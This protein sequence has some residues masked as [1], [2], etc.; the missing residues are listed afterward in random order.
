LGLAL[1]DALTSNIRKLERRY[2]DGFSCA[3]SVQRATPEVHESEQETPTEAVLKEHL[4]LH[5]WQ[6]GAEALVLCYEQTPFTQEEVSYLGEQLGALTRFLARCHIHPLDDTSVPASRGGSKRS[7]LDR[8]LGRFPGEMEEEEEDTV[9]VDETP[10]LDE[11]DGLFSHTARREVP[12]VSRLTIEQIVRHIIPNSY[13]LYI[14]RS[15]TRASERYPAVRMSFFKRHLKLI[16]ASQKGKSSMAA[17][18]LDIITR[19]H[20]PEHVLL[21][22]LDLEDQTSKLFAHLPH[23]AEVLV[24]DEPV[25][26]HARSREQV[27]EQ[28]G[29]VLS[30]MEYRYRLSK[31][32]LATEPILL[33]YVE[34]FL[35][36]KDYFK[37][38]IDSVRSG[39]KDQAKADY[40]QL[41][42]AISELARRG[43][44][45]RVQLLL[46][47]QVDY[48]D[49]D[50]QEALINITAGMSF[51]VRVTAAQAAGFY[52]VDLL[53]RNALDNTL[54]QAVVETPDCTDLV[55]APEYD[56]EQ[57]LLAFE[58]AELEQERRQHRHSAMA[59][60]L[61]L[62]ARPQT[63]R[64][65]VPSADQSSRRVMV[66]PPTPLA[67]EPDDKLPPVSIKVLAVP[68]ERK[69]QPALKDAIVCWNE[70]IEAGENPSRNN[71][72]QALLAKGFECKEYWARKFYEDIKEML[73]NQQQQNES[74]GE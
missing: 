46:C 38:R 29:Y 21:A 2:P 26:L 57:R 31:L 18:L 11:E 69:P 66:P 68:A 60:P 34:E 30:V 61:A 4:K 54:G 48:R 59:A 3:A 22:L 65:V 9:I 42:F 55:L 16:G 37:R 23:V 64:E 8:A 70:L 51:A 72:Q 13:S 27:L 28:L 6:A 50:L 40:A 36:L 7:L 19:T 53:K 1:E 47:A 25:R 74:A 24:G 56:L 62:V 45:A 33:V 5:I 12:G 14:G 17:A 20:D 52:H 73:S 44:K 71:L 15:L 39:E 43:L 35:A 41:I 63:A 49:E 10:R 32:E 58:Q 67:I